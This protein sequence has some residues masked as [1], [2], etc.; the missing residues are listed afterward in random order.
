MRRIFI[1]CKVRSSIFDGEY[2]VTILVE[3]RGTTQHLEFV[4]D[5]NSVNVS[6][7]PTPSPVDGEV[8]VWIDDSIPDQL[9]V[10]IPGSGGSDGKI[11][12]KRDLVHS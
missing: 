11:I 8:S 1:N 9:R 7:E 12:N 3:I 4:T 6:S 5:K 2:I 10:I